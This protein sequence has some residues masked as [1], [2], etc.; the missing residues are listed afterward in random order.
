MQLTGIPSG[1][2]HVRL[3]GKHSKS[4]SLSQIL[5]VGLGNGAC[6]D[7]LSLISAYARGCNICTNI[8]KGESIPANQPQ[9]QL[10][11]NSF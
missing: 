10:G 9:D 7:R 4:N 5:F 11:K 1:G 8:E 3:F 2:A 6:A